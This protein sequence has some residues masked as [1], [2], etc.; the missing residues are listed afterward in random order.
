MLSILGL[1]LYEFIIFEEI[2]EN[3]GLID[4]DIMYRWNKIGWITAYLEAICILI[5]VA[6]IVGF[7][8]YRLTRAILDKLRKKS[9][10][11]PEA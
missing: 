7:C 10:N 2:A 1:K 8:F 11:H 9:K 6:N 4:I 3:S 5:S